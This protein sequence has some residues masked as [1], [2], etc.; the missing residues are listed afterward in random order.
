MGR[1]RKAHG[2]PGSEPTEAELDTVRGLIARHEIGPLPGIAL[3]ADRLAQFRTECSRLGSSHAQLERIED[4][5]REV[6]AYLEGHQLAKR[7]V[8]WH[9]LADLDWRSAGVAI[10]ERPAHGEDHVGIT[11]SFCAIAETGTVLLLC[12]P[13]RPKATALLPETH[14]CVARRSRLVTR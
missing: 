12:A 7:A 3:P 8:A 13:H 1:I 9:E 11:G 2:R 5:P 6:A 10:D 14:I 4:V